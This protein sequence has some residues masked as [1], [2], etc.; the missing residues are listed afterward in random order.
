MLMRSGISWIW[1]PL[2]SGLGMGGGLKIKQ[3]R[4]PPTSPLVSKVFHSISNKCL[5]RVC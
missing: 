2:T 3:R 4:N 1:A 5:S